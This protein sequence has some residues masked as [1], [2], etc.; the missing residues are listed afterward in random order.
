[1]STD[2]FA[3]LPFKQK[4]RWLAHYFKVLTKHKER[5]RALALA[6][7]VPCGG[8]IFDVGAHLGYLT[9]EFATAHQGRIQVVAF[10]PG[11]YC[12]SI[13]SR[14]V[15][16]LSN[17]QLLKEGLGDQDTESLLKTPIKKSGMLGIGISQ[18]GGDMEGQFISSSIKVSK[19]DTL[20]STRQVP[21][22]D[23]LKVDV[24]GGELNVLMGAK[25][26]IL[27]H[28]P[29][30]YLEIEHY[31]TERFGYEPKDIFEFLFSYGYDAYQ[32]DLDGKLTRV[33]GYVNPIDYLF[34]ARA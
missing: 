4:F 6:S 3:S 15:R 2:Y 23:L 22:P 18:V 33:S 17:V 19:L 20:L 34:I 1:M 13:L 29:I 24:E 10:E 16:S 25:N 32:M 11:D 12:W 21:I 30:W 31:H 8:V 9:K 7:H 26:L 5:R 14:V 28:R 27:E